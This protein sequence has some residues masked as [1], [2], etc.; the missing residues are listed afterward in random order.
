[1]YVHKI[2]AYDNQLYQNQRKQFFIYKSKSSIF[3]IWK[4]S[5]LS[6]ACTDCMYNSKRFKLLLL[7]N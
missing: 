3:K 5:V 6:I 2:F 1:M 4:H 7:F